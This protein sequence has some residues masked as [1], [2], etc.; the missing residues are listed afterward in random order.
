MIVRPCLVYGPGVRFNLASLL[1]AVRRGRYIHVGSTSPVRSLASVDTVA[2][3]IVHLLNR[4]SAG[5]TYDLADRTPVH[6]HEW[7]NGLADRMGV[8][9]PRT[10]PLSI[11]RPL[12]ATLTPV[13]RLGLSVPLT[14]DTLRKLTTSFSLNVDALARTG[15]VWPDT[16]DRVLDQMVQ[17]AAE[18][19]KIAL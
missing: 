13:A 11:L 6:L 2:A 18:E 1:R 4:G 14:L 12:A 15:F 19:A 10:L 3:A 9:H 17:A 16:M 5:G 8:A 7:V